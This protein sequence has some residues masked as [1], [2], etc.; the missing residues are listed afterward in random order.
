MNEKTFFVGLDDSCLVMQ[1]SWVFGHE[2]FIICVSL[3]KTMRQFLYW[4]FGKSDLKN[5]LVD[6]GF[7]T[8]IHFMDTENPDMEREPEN[9]KKQ[10][11]FQNSTK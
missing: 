10:K 11:K 1:I 9:L 2:K 8:A 4:V 5:V 3:H 7:D 6:I